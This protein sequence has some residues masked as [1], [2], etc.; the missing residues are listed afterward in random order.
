[1]IE[2]AVKRTVV[3]LDD[4]DGGEAVETVTFA[5][6]GV[7]YTIDL[8]SKHASELR[9]RIA[10]YVG[11]A[12]RASSGTKSRRV[13]IAKAPVRHVDPA[14]KEYL[15]KVRAWA[16]QQGHQVAERGRV[17]ESIVQKYEESLRAPKIDAAPKRVRRSRKAP[18][19][20]VVKPVV[21]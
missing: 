11:H 18:Q 10:T 4:I 6:D 15:A 14:R 21:E 17:A 13:A 9:E 16:A 20:Q 5:L 2:M 8:S 7:E 19:L 3:L 1:M 12:R